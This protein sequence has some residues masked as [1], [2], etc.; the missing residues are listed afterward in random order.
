MTAANAIRYF[1]NPQA[2][3]AAWGTPFVNAAS[4]LERA[5]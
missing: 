5:R 1:C 3:P 2:A 4:A